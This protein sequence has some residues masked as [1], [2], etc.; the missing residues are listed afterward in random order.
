M[1]GIA[2]LW[3]KGLRHLIFH[4]DGVKVCL[5]FLEGVFYFCLKTAVYIEILKLG[6]LLG[7]KTSIVDNTFKKSCLSAQYLLFDIKQPIK[8][9]HNIFS[10]ISNLS[11][12]GI[13]K[14]SVVDPNFKRQNCLSYHCIPYNPNSNFDSPLVYRLKN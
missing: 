2:E 14:L 7:R 4:I 3:G 12:L 8:N 13:R 11:A 6:C 1:I 10:K 5:F 9:T